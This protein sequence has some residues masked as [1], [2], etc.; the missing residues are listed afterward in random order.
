[1]NTRQYVAC[2]F[3]PGDHR[4]YTYHNDGDPVDVGDRVRVPCRKG[5]RPVTVAAIVGVEPSFQTKAILGR[6]EPPAQTG[7]L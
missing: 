3:S 7:L 4:T 5:E 2:Q 1:M 6:V